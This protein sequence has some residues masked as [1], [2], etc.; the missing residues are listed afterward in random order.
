MLK[1]SR[2]RVLLQRLFSSVVVLPAIAC[3]SAAVSQTTPI[4]FASTYAGLATGASPA[5]AVCSAS[6]SVFAVSGT[7]AKYGDGCPATQASLNVPVG[8]AT[9]KFGNLFIADQTN[10]LVRVVYNGGMA[11]A[12]AL[13]N[14]NV[15]NP[16]LTPVKGDIYTIAGGPTATPTEATKYCNQA[17]SGIIGTDNS[18]DGC[19][20][21]ESEQGPRAVA[22]DADGN[23]FISSV[24]PVSQIRVIFVGGAA[25]TRLITLEN[26]SITS[27][28]PGYVYNIAGGNASSYTGDGALASKATMNT[29][30]G[31]VIDASENIYFVDQLNNVVR[32]VDGTTGFISTV[33]GH[34]IASGTSC[35][36][37]ATSGDGSLATST[38]VN[39]YYPYGVALDQYGNLFIAEGGSATLPGRIRVVYAGGTV[40]GLPTPTTPGT[41]YTYAGGAAATGTQAQEAT[42]QLVYGVSIDP[43]GY[44][45]V[46]D[47]RSGTTGSNHIWRVDPVSG[48]IVILAG[49]GSTILANTTHC[50]R[51][52]QVGIVSADNFGDGC[53]AT[54]AYL[55]IPQ[56]AVAFDGNGNAYFADRGDNLV[57]KLAYN[58]VFPATA[59][60]STSTA[61][62]QAF[63]YP[64]ITTLTNKSA[65]LQGAATTE[66]VVVTNTTTNV[67]TC[68]VAAP[69]PA[70]ANTCVNYLAFA[71]AAAGLRSAAYNNSDVTG[72]VATEPV[73]GIGIA[74]VL[75][76]NPPSPVAI[77]SGIT[78][79]GISTDLK[80]DVYVSDSKGKQVILS[81]IAGGAGTAVI[82]GLGTPR[83]STVDNFGNLY[84]ADSTNSSIVKLPAGSATKSTVVS[85]LSA[86][87]GVV[88]DL[89]GNV[90]IADTG[91]NR[92]LSFNS[93][94]GNTTPVSTYPLTLSAPTSLAL[95]SVGNLYIIDSANTR[96][97]ELSVGQPA[98][99]LTLSNGVTPAALGFD[100]ANDT[101]FADTTS[102]SILFE[103][104]GTMTASALITGI[105]TPTGVAI[106]SNGNLF[107]ADSAATGTGSPAPSPAATGYNVALN[108]SVFTTTNI[109]LTSLPITLT[110]SDVGNL[111]ATLS[112]PP[113]IETGSAAAFPAYGTSTCTAGLALA[114]GAT[115]TQTFD[116][117]PTVPGPQSAKV[118]FSD[119]ASQT[120]TAN[121]SGTATN[122]ILTTLA[123]SPQNATSN[124][125]VTTNYTVTLTPKSIGATTPTGMV[126][127]VVDGKT[128]SMQNV[129]TAPYIYIFP[130]STSVAI[131]SVAAVYSGDAVYAGSNT[132]TL[133]TVNKANTSIVA[134][135]TQSAA[136]TALSAVMTPASV[137]ALTF[138]GNVVF[139]VDSK[140]VATVAVG[141]GTVSATVL[142][143]DGSH[144]YYA[145]YVG[146][147]NYAGSTSTP[148]QTLI[149][150]R[151][152]TTTALTITPVSC[153]PT[154][155]LLLS[156]KV[157]STTA[158]TPTGT[159]LFSNNGTTLAT[160]NLSTAVNGVVTFTTNTTTY[161]NYSFT[162][163]YSGDGLYDPSSS[164]VTE[165]PDFAVI[166]PTTILGV[167][168]GGQAVY[169]CAP[170]SGAC[171]VSAATPILVLPINGYSGSLTASCDGLPAYA[172][173]RFQPI[174]VV[175]TSTSTSAVILT[176]QVFAGVNPAVGSM[177][178]P[179][180]HGESKT[181]FALLLLSPAVFGL[182]R[183][184]KG[185][186]GRALPSLLAFALLALLTA[187][188]T[189]CG[190]KTPAYS[191]LTY[192]TADGT[193]PITLTLKDTNNVSRSAVFTITV[194]N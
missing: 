66:F 127:F 85:G 133:L 137:G 49:T 6:L 174:P 22:T 20:A 54:Q 194:I 102:G 109:T 91:N 88:A 74:P 158:G 92:I 144:T 69:I 51:V 10:M 170:S 1:N 135:Y 151:A 185:V 189:G 3:A 28:I 94:N 141:N 192:R 95:D 97:V 147:A 167:P 182:L 99:V 126:T 42:F 15:Q 145:T 159:V 90:Y 9:D 25:V 156:A 173:C 62:P 70:A 112:T 183:R 73:S 77:G 171:T 43:A 12:T 36:A 16:G 154:A 89:F 96:V 40:P 168:Q 108:N 193:Y 142:I 117:A 157:A 47:Y 176:V 67:D 125:G 121:L 179:S 75:T 39:I 166:T 64:T 46:T 175:L 2:H 113:Y 13:G 41:I 38:A 57:R 63:Y 56:N 82:T 184:R 98:V 52:K 34:C 177:T 152:P 165:G 136:G 138:T 155:C 146:D 120:V 7:G 162:A 81:S 118:V 134:S 107:V 87:Q 188:I 19:P 106:G 93:V 140:V 8:V 148:V 169:P 129:S 60:G 65:T 30:R 161:T 61:L 58:N 44:L 119:T 24:S 83:Q 110:L 53:P 163:A 27:P 21:S 139:Y 115:C 23:I 103:P 31:L 131:H 55:N 35:T 86:P 84:V 59:V 178:R 150:A 104:V 132:T 122:L 191:E 114:T 105:T 18:L 123:I 160:I 172:F 124:Y 190:D 180:L 50:D 71:P 72:I 32:R 153:Y 143:A 100:P 5:P 29:P 80:G 116:F 186:T 11:L 4:P 17:G 26:P 78:P 181:L 48:N 149:V 45:Y 101:Y 68:P 33:A 111:T 187:G 37:T 14:S 130:L 76:I 79:S 164:T 128:V